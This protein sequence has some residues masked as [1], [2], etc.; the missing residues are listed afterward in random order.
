[1]ATYS[2][3]AMDSWSLKLKQ[4]MDDFAKSQF[5][6]TG[7]DILIARKFYAKC[8]LWCFVIKKNNVVSIILRQKSE[9]GEHEINLSLQRYMELR[10]NLNNINDAFEKLIQEKKTECKIHLGA[11]YYASLSHTFWIVHIGEWYVNNV[12]VFKP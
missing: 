11:N 2:D 7:N 3:N 1:M 10:K 5:K 8:G 12:G 4:K 6:L 9:K